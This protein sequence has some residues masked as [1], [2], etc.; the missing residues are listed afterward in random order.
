LEFDGFFASWFCFL[1]GAA[2]RVWCVSLW[3]L[4]GGLSGCFAL[5]HGSEAESGGAGRYQNCGC[6]LDFDPDHSSAHP[7]G[8]FGHSRGHDTG[9]PVTGRVPQRGLERDTL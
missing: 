2:R 7:L 8:E 5:R 3:R 4:G 6:N 1:L 9:C